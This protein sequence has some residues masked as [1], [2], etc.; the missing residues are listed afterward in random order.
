MSQSQTPHSKFLASLLT[1]SSRGA[2]PRA[3]TPRPNLATQDSIFKKRGRTRSRRFSNAPP[4]TFFHSYFH[5][6]V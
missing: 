2:N 3:G 1:S 6:D 4:V 5:V